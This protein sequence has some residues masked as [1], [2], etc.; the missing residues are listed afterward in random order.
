MAAS[1][2]CNALGMIHHVIWLFRSHKIWQ[3]LQP[4]PPLSLLG[5]DGLDGQRIRR[6]GEGQS[7]SQAWWSVTSPLS[8]C[9]IVVGTSLYNHVYIYMKS[10]HISRREAERS[11]QAGRQT[12]TGRRDHPRD[13]YRAWFEA[14][15]WL[16]TL[17]GCI[18]RPVAFEMSSDHTF[19]FQYPPVGIGIGI[20]S[21]VKSSHLPD[22]VP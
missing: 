12:N 2:K 7:A 18:V 20:K 16:T 22:G 6:R 15:S 5:L 19:R 14:C 21:E 3:P 11:C 4:P 9:I 13:D 10:V 1:N 17:T 8:C